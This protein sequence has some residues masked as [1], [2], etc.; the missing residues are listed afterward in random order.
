MKNKLIEISDTLKLKNNSELNESLIK[1]YEFQKKRILKLKK[2]NTD[3]VSPMVRIDSS[4]TTFMREDVVG[5]TLSK[6]II[7]K[8]APSTTDGYISIKK[9]VQ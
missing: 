2:I 8:N 5:E 3:G 4:E 9:V 7:L 1:E 6:E